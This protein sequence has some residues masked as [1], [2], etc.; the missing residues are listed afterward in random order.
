MG[1]YVGSAELNPNS[2][3]ICVGVCACVHL[4]MAMYVCVSVWVCVHVSGG[5]DLTVKSVIDF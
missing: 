2:C 1:G 3:G 4:C 5:R